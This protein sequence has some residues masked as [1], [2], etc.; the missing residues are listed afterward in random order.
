MRLESLLRERLGRHP[1]EFPHSPQGPY[2]DYN[3]NEANSPRKGRE[4]NGREEHNQG[5]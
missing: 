3:S 2:V 5:R 1:F 4:N